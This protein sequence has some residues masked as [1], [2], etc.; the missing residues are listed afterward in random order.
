MS[1]LT[2]IQSQKLTRY[3]DSV[4]LDIFAVMIRDASLRPQIIDNHIYFS[5]VSL[6]EL[7]GD[8]KRGIAPSAIWKNLKRSLK[9]YD[10]QLVSNL[11]LLPM[12]ASDGKMYLSD[13]ADLAT[14]LKI[15][16]RM[17]TQNA[18]ELSD[19]IDDRVAGL[20]EAVINYRVMNIMHGMEWA[21]DATHEAMKGLEPTP[22]DDAWRDLGYSK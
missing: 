21:A 5:M 16:H 1:D 13:A 6:M 11:H 18:R 20:V 8:S 7:L 14:V 3:R 19:L 10:S 9:K 15:M 12:R 17:R 4:G 22:P 2:P